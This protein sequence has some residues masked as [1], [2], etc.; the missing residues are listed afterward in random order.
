METFAHL[1]VRTN[2]PKNGFVVPEYRDTATSELLDTLR[3]LLLPNSCYQDRLEV[4]LSNPTNRSDNLIRDPCGVCSYCKKEYL[5]PK[6]HREGVCEVLF[7]ILVHGE[8]AIRGVAFYPTV[9]RS[10][11]LFPSVGSL[12]FRSQAKTVSPKSIKQILLVLLAA[13]ILEAGVDI[14][15]ESQNEKLE[16]TLSLALHPPGGTQFAMHCD[17]FWNAI[18]THV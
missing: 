9:V 3:L 6:L 5:Y 15:G 2:D 4:L 1:W 16:M 13:G 8:N 7:K 14:D 10:M 18:R 11:Q 17:R 12:L